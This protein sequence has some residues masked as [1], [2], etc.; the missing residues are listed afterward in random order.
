MMIA[1]RMTLAS[2]DIGF[3]SVKKTRLAPGL[4]F[5]AND[6]L[7]LPRQG[8]VAPTSSCFQGNKSL[9]TQG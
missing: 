6:L 4:G 3:S 2:S 1:P 9:A 7:A 5:M 8:T